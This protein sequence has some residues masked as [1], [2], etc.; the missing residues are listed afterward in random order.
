MGLMR[1]PSP[2]PKAA[3]PPAARRPWQDELA[4]ALRDPAEVLAALDL[5]A[6]LAA[7]AAAGHA[8]FRTFVPRPFLARMRPGDPRDPL[9]LQVLA[10]AQEALPGGSLD[11]L[12]EGP[13]AAAPGLLAKYPGRVLLVTTG[14]CAIHCRYCFRRHFP[15]GEVPV[16]PEAQLAQVASH[17]AGHPEVDEVLLSGGDPLT[18]PPAAFARLWSGLDAMPGLRRLR[19]HT[20]LP[21]VLPSRVDDE[22]CARLAETRAQVYVVIHANHARELDDEVAAAC[23]RLRRA[24]AAVLNQAVLLAGVNDDLEAQVDLHRRLADLGVV[25]YYLHL[26]DPVAGARHF[27]VSREAGLALVAQMRARLPGYAVPQLVREVPGASSKLPAE[28]VE[29]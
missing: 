28:A 4:A 16:A 1:R 20:R 27:E 10:G 7:E 24:G 5:P 19:L 22:L 13:A 6:S 12:E 26:L 15:Y 21:V 17:L 9:L 25:A 29:V 2:A 18:L 3:P 8:Q 14:V 11:P 23:A